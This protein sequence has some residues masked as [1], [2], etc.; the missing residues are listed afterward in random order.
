MTGPTF[1]RETTRSPWQALGAAALGGLLVLAVTND[2]CAPGAS[3]LVGATAPSF[4]LPIVGGEG[5][6]SGDRLDLAALRGHVVVLDFW[7]S[8]CPPCRASVPA[9]EA[10]SRAH[11]DVRV[12]GV[13]VE[14]H[15]DPAFVADAHARLGASYPTVQDVDGSLERAY[16][17]RGLPTLLVV[18]RDGVIRTAHVGAV[19]RRWLETNVPTVEAR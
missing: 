13:N 3:P 4:A 6:A 1:D 15:R 11:P 18:D 8:W 14:A 2:L 7:A 10:F 9:I 16:G 19:D 12:V 5:A 17:I